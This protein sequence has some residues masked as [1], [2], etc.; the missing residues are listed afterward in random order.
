MTVH[1]Y[2]PQLSSTG[3]LSWQQ[4]GLLERERVRQERIPN[5]VA[6]FDVPISVDL[7]VWRNRV[8]AVVEREESLQAACGNSEPDTV[9][10]HG[11]CDD[12]SVWLTTA[13]SADDVTALERS[14]VTFAF[15]RS[16]PPWSLTLVEHPDRDGVVRHTALA[17]F[18]HLISDGRS[19]DLFAHELSMTTHVPPVSLGRYREW[20]KWQRHEFGDEDSPRRTSAVAKFWRD[21]LRGMTATTAIP[22]PFADSSVPVSGWLMTL[23]WRTESATLRQCA[24]RH[25]VTPFFL[26]LA[27]VASACARAADVEDLILRVLTMARQPRFATTLGYLADSIPLRLRDPRIADI[28]SALSV[29]KS[30]WLL[31]MPHQYA[32][33]DYILRVTSDMKSLVNRPTIVD[34]NYMR[35]VG[36]TNAPTNSSQTLQPVSQAGLRVSGIDTG[37]VVHVSCTFDPMRFTEAGVRLL[38]DGVTSGLCELIGSGTV[39]K[40]RSM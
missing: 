5:L 27:A 20:V 9:V 10:Y 25:R 4:R 3:P 35:H 21:Y 11:D 40:R 12:V 28:A 32:P 16:R 37:M 30:N 2:R 31:T 26:L 24:A 38:F 22:F 33:W 7:N 8:R 13:D 1:R 36:P 18:D 34:V 39:G 14:L 19:L 6:R 15:D 17:A 23:Q 29:V